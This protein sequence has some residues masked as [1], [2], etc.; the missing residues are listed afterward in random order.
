MRTVTLKARLRWLASTSCLTHQWTLSPPRDD[1]MSKDAK[2][3]SHPDR[4]CQDMGGAA[5]ALT[6][7]LKDVSVTEEFHVAY[8][9]TFLGT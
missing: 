6:T 8:R 2:P 4:G 3:A 9:H 1:D 5:T 7:T